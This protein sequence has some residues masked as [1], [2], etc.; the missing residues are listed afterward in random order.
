VD[1]IFEYASTDCPGIRSISH[2]AVAMTDTA[3]KTIVITGA[4][5]GIGAAAAKTLSQRGATVAVVGR[6]PE[7]TRDIARS[8]NGQA[9]LAD[10]A[11]FDSVR[12][13]AEGLLDRYESI[14]V[15]A[16]NAGGLVPKRTTTVD[17]HE[18]TIQM[19]HL[20]P[21]LLTALLL[22]RLQ[23]TAATGR[24]VRVIATASMAN[25]A[26]SLRLDD[27][28]RRSR[29]W[30]GG[31]PAYGG[32]KAANI[33]FTRELARRTEGTGISAY[34][35]HPG[36]VATG[37]G[38]DSPLLRLAGV[39]GYGRFSLTPDAGAAPLVELAS[40]SAVPQPSGTY[41]DGLVPGG[42]TGRQA[43]DDALAAS[44][45]DVSERLTAP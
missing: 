33:L 21:F 28:N 14:D 16:N 31:W 29:P 34:A 22:P 9:F 37:F 13:L 30:L 44:L 19:N 41:F 12:D 8:V 40:A 10:F 38:A 24:P 35:Y 20:S 17:G 18:L 32:A 36:F 25:V 11:S 27:L 15:L 5:S 3:T 6:N 2:Y 39:L 4:S 45:W 42:R 1:K 26:S 7:R 23:E 43:S